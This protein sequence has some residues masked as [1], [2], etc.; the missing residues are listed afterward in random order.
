QAE[1]VRE[2]EA[3]QQAFEK[4]LEVESRNPVYRRGL[5]WALACRVS[6]L[7]WMKKP[8]ELD[9]VAQKA[10]ALAEEL[11]DEEPDNL[12][13]VEELAL[14][15]VSRGYQL[16]T[17]ARYAEGWLSWIGPCRWWSA[18]SPRSQASNAM[19]SYLPSRTTIGPCAW[20]RS[21]GTRN[22]SKRTKNL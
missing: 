21:S 1:A 13:R 9:S 12:R 5:S 2:A 10:I 22:E 7:H 14:L 18:S 4:L 15:R 16:G 3:A 17:W 8:G 20:D 6:A 19:R 11:R